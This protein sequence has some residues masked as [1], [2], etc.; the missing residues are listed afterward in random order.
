MPG[1]KQDIID[2]KNKFIRRSENSWLVEGLCSIDEFREYF[3]I[4]EELPGEAEDYYKT[5][6]GFITYLLGYIPKETE[7]QPMT[8]SHSKSWT[9]TTAEWIRYW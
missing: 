4:E 3:H 8:D 9:A 5:L 2:E 6:G 7:K 1:D